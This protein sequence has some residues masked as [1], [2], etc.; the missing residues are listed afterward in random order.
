MIIELHLR[1]AGYDVL[2]TE[3]GKK[4]IELASTGEFDLIFC[5][6]KLRGES[7]IDVIKALKAMH[8]NTPVVAATG[9]IGDEIISK[10]KEAGADDYIAKPFTKEALLSIVGKYLLPGE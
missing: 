9:F 10:V 3:S 8:I 1:S 7:G 4:G 6:I 2:T 5:D